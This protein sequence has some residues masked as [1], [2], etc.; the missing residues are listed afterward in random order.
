MLHPVTDQKKGGRKIT[1][2]TKHIYMKRK[3]RT[4]YWGFPFKQGK[5]PSIKQNTYSYC[6]LWTSSDNIDPCQLQGADI[7]MKMDYLFPSPGQSEILR[8]F[9][10]GC[11]LN[12]MSIRDKC[13]YLP[14]SLKCT[15]SVT[16]LSWHCRTEGYSFPFRRNRTPIPISARLISNF[17]FCPWLLTCQVQHVGY[18]TL[19]WKS[20]KKNAE[21]ANTQTPGK[22]RNKRTN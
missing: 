13:C 15:N 12:K 5:V 4:P 3:G 14:S 16:F 10:L 9:S 17:L 11:F 19:L 8:H 1:W 18:W 7:L 2:S 22:A 6:L 21:A 20:I